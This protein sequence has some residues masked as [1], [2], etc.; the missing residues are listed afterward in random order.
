MIKFKGTTQIYGYWNDMNEPSVF[1]NPVMT[2]PLNSLHYT[3][4]GKAVM[5]RDVHNMY[6]AL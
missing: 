2:L 4:E 6:G 1:N 5:H 3:K